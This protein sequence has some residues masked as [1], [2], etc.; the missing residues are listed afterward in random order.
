MPVTTDG[1]CLGLAMLTQMLG[2]ACA[3]QIPRTLGE[4][5]KF[6]MSNKQPWTSPKASVKS[7]LVEGRGIFANADIKRG[8]NLIVWGG[9]Y[10]DKKGVENY[11][12]QGKLVMQ[13]D[14]DVYSVFHQPFL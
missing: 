9:N 10:T 13:W 5:K 2:S 7:S 12:K 6:P 8:E 3:S 14:D 11:L 4:I 1:T